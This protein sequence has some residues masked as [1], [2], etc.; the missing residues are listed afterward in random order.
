MHTLYRGKD[1][2][3]KFCVALREHAKNIIDFEKKKNVTTNKIKNKIISRRKIK[4][5]LEKKIVK[6]LL[7][8][9]INENSET[10]VIM[11]VNLETPHIVFVI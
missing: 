10:I 7:K 8:I 5:Y 6:S 11:Q 2:M 9:K 3:K 1:Y 4:L